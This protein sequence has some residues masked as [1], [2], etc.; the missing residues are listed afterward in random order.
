MCSR[1]DISTKITKTLDLLTYIPVNDFVFNFAFMSYIKL[2]ARHKQKESIKEEGTSR[3]GVRST[4]NVCLLAL[5]SQM[6]IL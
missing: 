1:E 5:S 4:Y 3:Q 2:A 6:Y